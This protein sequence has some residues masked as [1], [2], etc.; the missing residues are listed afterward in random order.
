MFFV[1][2]SMSLT[3]FSV[4][5]GMHE[6]TAGAFFFRLPPGINQLEKLVIGIWDCDE[7]MS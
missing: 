1:L 6:M 3:L 4:Y 2:H 7:G 5:L